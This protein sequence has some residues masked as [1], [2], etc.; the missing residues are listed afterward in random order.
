MHPCGASASKQR[1]NGYLVIVPFGLTSTK[2]NVPTLTIP[3]LSRL[4]LVV[5][6]GPA[7]VPMLVLLPVLVLLA[8]LLPVLPGLSLSLLGLHLHSPADRGPSSL[9][10]AG[11]R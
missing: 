1:R 6:P 8:V 5:F 11:T 10:L 2:V 9:L 3:L 7:L 4:V